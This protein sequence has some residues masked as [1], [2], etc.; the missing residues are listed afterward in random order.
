MAYYKPINL[1]KGD[2]LPFLEIT[3]RDSNSA[4]VGQTLSITDPT[5]WKPI[6]LTNV[7]TV[8]FKFR[9]IDTSTLLATISC[10][11]L[12]PYID[13]K[14][15]MNWGLTTL[16]GGFGDYEGEIEI[17]YDDAKVLTIPDRFKF[18]VRDQF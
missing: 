11:L 7:S 17:T 18:V 5:T 4:A 13:G 8:L 6:D 14:V 15:T 12:T 1:V 3:L 9:K 16:D 10:T 2:D